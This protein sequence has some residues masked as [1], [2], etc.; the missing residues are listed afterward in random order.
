MVSKLVYNGHSHKIE[1]LDDKGTSLG[2][3]VAYNN[4][5]HAFAKAHYHSITH[6]SNGTYSVQDSRV[7]YNHAAD[8]NGPYGSH[9]IIRF[10]YPGHPG[11][12]LHSGRANAKIMPGPLHATHG[13]IRTSDE[14][15]AAIK[16]IIATDPVK[17]M[18]I[19]GNSEHSVKHGMAKHHAL[20]HGEHKGPIHA[21]R[22]THSK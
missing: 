22:H 1:L 8:A 10:H 6:L 16:S 3:W 11:V 4:I 21:A 20:H 12:G 15:M 7:P 18:T 9:G 2:S 17:T 5:D 14:A 13:C 19:F